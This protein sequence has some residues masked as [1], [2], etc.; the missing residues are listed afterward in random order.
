MSEDVTAQPTGL[1][2]AAAPRSE[3]KMNSSHVRALLRRRYQHPEWALCFEVANATGGGSSRYADAVAMNL[4]PSRGLAVHG[5]EIKVS[6]QDYMGEISNP[7]KSAPVQKYCDFWW[8]VAPAKAV[9]ESLLPDTWGWLEVKDEQMIARKNAP[10][11]EATPLD[12]AFMAAMV[13]RSSEID[14]SEVKKAVELEL[15]RH[16]END[17]KHVEAEITRRTQKGADAIAIVEELRSKLGSQGWRM[18]D[19]PE[20]C[21]AVQ[22]LQ[23]LGLTST[24]S[25]VKHLQQQ[26]TKSAAEIEAA[27]KP[28]IGGQDQL[29]LEAAE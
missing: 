2:L 6:K 7:A 8:I 10:K 3:V 24:Y 9:D 19:A 14:S 18:L 15:A 25:S 26:L 28:L 12:R 20:I 1:S 21:A 16:R 27:M 23:K 29:D 5:F 22:V 4:W 11:L 13:R 17:K